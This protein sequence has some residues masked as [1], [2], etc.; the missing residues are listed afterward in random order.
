MRVHF[1]LSS[2]GRYLE[3]ALVWASSADSSRFLRAFS[4]VLLVSTV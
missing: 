1:C 4:M 2:V 3:V